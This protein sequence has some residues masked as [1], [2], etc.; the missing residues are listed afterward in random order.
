MCCKTGQNDTLKW[1]RYLPSSTYTSSPKPT[2]F[3]NM[4]MASCALCGP[5]TLQRRITSS[6]KETQNCKWCWGEWTSFGS[7]PSVFKRC[8]VGEY[9]HV[10]YALPHSIP[11]SRDW[12]I[13]KQVYHIIWNTYGR[14][15]V[16]LLLNVVHLQGRKRCFESGRWIGYIYRRYSTVVIVMDDTASHLSDQCF[17]WPYSSTTGNNTTWCWQYWLVHSAHCSSDQTCCPRWLDRYG[18][19]DYTPSNYGFGYCEKCKHIFI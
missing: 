7:R 5:S 19:A 9:N 3:I 1:M 10:A 17:W 16:N 14:R 18:T 13:Q 11:L 2:F 8:L 4:Q 12:R 6:T 15:E